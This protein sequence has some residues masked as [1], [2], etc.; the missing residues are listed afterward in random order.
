MPDSPK[1]APGPLT[2]VF[3]EPSFPEPAPASAKSPPQPPSPG[4]PTRPASAEA[5]SRPVPPAA[6]AGPTCPESPFQGATSKAAVSGERTPQPTSPPAA[7]GAAAPAATSAPLT[8]LVIVDGANVVGSVPD[9]WWRDRAGAAARLRDNLAPIPA[10]GLGGLPGPVELILV[11]EGK[12]RDIPAA[13]AG[14]RIARAPGSG[15]DRIVD[16]V[17]AEQGSRHIVVITAD[18]GLRDRVTALGAEVRGPSA[19]PR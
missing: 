10:A 3:R 11:V 13:T 15:D 18:R 1:P 6:P 5:A 14:V 4:S 16:L 17:H 9:G 19:V 7:V 12:A 2:P 8:P